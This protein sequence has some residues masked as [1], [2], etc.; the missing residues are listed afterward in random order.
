ARLRRGPHARRGAVS[1]IWITPRGSGVARPR[2]GPGGPTAEPMSQQPLVRQAD[3]RAATLATRVRAL[4]SQGS[5]DPGGWAAR[6]RSARAPLAPTPPAGP[7]VESG[8]AEEVLAP[9]C[10]G[11]GRVRGLPHVGY[12]RADQPVYSADLLGDPMVG[13]FFQRIT[14]GA[15]REFYTELGRQ[16]ATVV[17]CPLGR[18]VRPV[19]GGPLTRIVLDV[20]QGAIYFYRLAPG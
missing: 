19:I 17:R 16:F 20:E 12:Y 13:R 10:R 8:Q 18:V 4:L 14:P 9:V 6:Q 11:A 5:Q 2:D 1:C 3:Q 7:P 15:R